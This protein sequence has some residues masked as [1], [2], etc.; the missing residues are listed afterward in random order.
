M[1]NA[2]RHSAPTETGVNDPADPEPPPDVVALAGAFG[3][4]DA[5][6][7]LPVEQTGCADD[8]PVGDAEG[9]V[10]GE[11]PTADELAPNDADADAE[12]S[13]PAAARESNR[14]TP[15]AA[16]VVI[17]VNWSSEVPLFTTITRKTAAP[18]FA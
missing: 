11:V 8:E 13:E 18:P 5:A 6:V 3:L 4:L 2:A 12:T 15:E 14:L 9:V 1:P 7:L 17:E 16:G 10:P